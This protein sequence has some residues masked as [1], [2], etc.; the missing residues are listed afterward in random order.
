MPITSGADIDVD[1]MP[2][3]LP[4]AM[5]RT[6]AADVEGPPLAGPPSFDTLFGDVDALLAPPPPR[7]SA[8][9]DDAESDVGRIVGGAER[10]STPEAVAPPPME[11]FD[12]KNCD[13]PL[14]WEKPWRALWNIACA[15][16]DVEPVWV[17]AGPVGGVR[18]EGAISKSRTEDTGPL[19]MLAGMPL[20]KLDKRLWSSVRPLVEV[21]SVFTM[22]SSAPIE[23]FIGGKLAPPRRNAFCLRTSARWWE[24]AA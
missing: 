6:S 8:V 14:V 12:K 19:L 17:A 7:P 13:G 16:V 11:S 5:S 18:P 4:R 20:V 3:T 15:L 23:P 10:R 22:E 1:P 2:G 24:M 9:A 21:C